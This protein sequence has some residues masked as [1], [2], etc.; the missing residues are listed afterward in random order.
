MTEVTTTNGTHRLPGGLLRSPAFADSVREARETAAA[1]GL[2]LFD[3]FDPRFNDDPFTLYAE[4]RRS[5]PVHRSPLGFWVFTRHA[6][7][8][9]ILRDKR[10]S[11]DARNVDPE[12]IG[13]PVVTVGP[14]GP[15]Q[16]IYDD[17]SPFIFRDPPDHTRLRGIVQKAFTPR[18]VDSLRDRVSQLAR[19]LVD[20]ALERGEVDLVADFAYALPVRIIAEMLGVPESDH[21]LF[22]GWSDALA[23]G[24]DPDFLLPPEAMQERFDALIAFIAYFGNL[25]GERRQNPGDDLLS[26]LILAEED[27]VM[28]TQGELIATCILILVAGHETTVNLMSGGVLELM[29]HRDQLARFRD[30]PGVLRSGVEEMLRFVSPVQLTGRTA[31]EDMEV[32]DA[33][34]LKGEFAMLLIGSA[35]RD[36]SVFNDPETFDVGRAEN[37]HLS[38][39]FGVHHCLGASLARLEAHVALPELIGRTKSI[40]LAT[41]RLVYR[42]NITL[43]GLAA[44]P[45]RIT[46]S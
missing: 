36:P 11:S 28:L 4:L 46:A 3:P 15:A 20:D 39:G 2:L 37:P 22:K 44:L 29:R 30:D 16:Q 25:I 26:K 38:L 19:S 41:D 10:S 5:N 21:D 18:V 13:A 24:L 33:E 43:R 6:D 31:L 1:K 7:C 45:V 42:E 23:R 34:L 14:E 12:A 27:G 40:E 35:N 32:G 8:L 9:A 17:L